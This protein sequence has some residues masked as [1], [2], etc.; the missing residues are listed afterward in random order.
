MKESHRMELPREVWMGPNVTDEIIRLCRR[1]SLGFNALIVTGEKT[2]EIAG[3]R[4][5]DNLES[6]DYNVNHI[7]I[8][9]ADMDSIDKV[10]ENTSG[11]NFLLGVGGGTCIDVSKF[12]SFKKGIPF[13]SIPT[14]ASH[15]GISS[16]RASIKGSEKS[17][18]FQ[19]QAP[20]AVVA[21]TLIIKDAPF[22]LLAAGCGDMISNYTAVWDWKLAHKLKK[23]SYSE[24]AAAL[25]KMSAKIIMENANVIAEAKEESVRK[26]VKAL[27]SSGV[28]MSIAGSSRPASG[29]EHLFSHALDQIAPNPALHGEQCGVGSILMACLQKSGWQRIRKA[30]MTIGCPV[31]AEELNIKEEYIIEALV[32]ADEIRPDRYTVLKDGLDTDSAERLAK[33]TKVIG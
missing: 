3:A 1:L 28:A 31:N 4:I 15:D 13:I 33:K 14:A 32:K 17:T 30:L 8:N 6:G 23:E 7:V 19:A 5:S 11:V 18:S 21:D 25:S 27:I 26:V 24:Y 10:L 16:S 22:H 20:L 2:Y 9:K 29:S 12:A